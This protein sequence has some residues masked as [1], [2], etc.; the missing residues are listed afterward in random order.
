MYQDF[1]LLPF[2]QALL[3]YLHSPRLLHMLYGYTSFPPPEDTL[4]YPLFQDRGL[5]PS[6]RSVGDRGWRSGIQLIML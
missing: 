5:S 4:P 2:L 3:L 1:W 6:Y